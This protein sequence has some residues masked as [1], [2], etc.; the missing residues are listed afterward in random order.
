MDWLPFAL[1][2]LALLG[3]AVVLLRRRRRR[4]AAPDAPA[5]APASAPGDEVIRTRQQTALSE[6]RD[7]REALGP[8]AHSRVERRRNPQPGAAPKIERRKKGTRRAP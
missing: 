8:A 1:V 5:S 6:L 3:A 4:T 2:A 7:M